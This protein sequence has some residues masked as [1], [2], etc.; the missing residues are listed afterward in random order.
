MKVALITGAGTGIGAATAALLASR[1]YAVALNGR[2][3]EPLREVDGEHRGGGRPGGRGSR[4]HRRAGRCGASRGRGPCR[5]LRRPLLLRCLNAG[6]RRYGS[7]RADADAGGL[8]RRAAY[9]PH[10]RVPAVAR[11][12]LP[13][14]LERRGSIVATAP[15]AAFQA[16]P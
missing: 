3:E 4:R 12:A 5:R 10:G 6:I 8:G 2:R 13:H 1:G 16:G 11:A 14:L 15:A 9:Q 7:V